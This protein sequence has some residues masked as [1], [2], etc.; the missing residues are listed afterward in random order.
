MTPSAL[1]P[2][3]LRPTLLLPIRFFQAGYGPE[4]AQGKSQIHKSFP[5]RLSS[6]AKLISRILWAFYLTVL[7]CLTAFFLFQVFVTYVVCVRR[8]GILSDFE[9]K[10]NSG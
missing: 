4:E 6:P 1:T 5:S 2:E 8:S 10:S 7:C 3:P 9:R